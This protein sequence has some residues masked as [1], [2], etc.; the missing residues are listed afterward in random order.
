MRLNREIDTIVQEVIEHLTQLTGSQVNITLEIS[1]T[2]DEGFPDTTVRTVSEN[3]RVL[4]FDDK[5]AR[6]VA[7]N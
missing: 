5:S 6:K 7:G 2:N 1:A 3:S 4:K